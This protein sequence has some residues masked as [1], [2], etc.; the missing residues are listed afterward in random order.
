M[1]K[2][3]ISTFGSGM[4]LG[5]VLVELTRWMSILCGGS[6]ACEPRK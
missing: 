5:M 1:L 6:V 4:V 2:S 3:W